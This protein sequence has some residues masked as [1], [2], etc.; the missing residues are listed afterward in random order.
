MV[1]I[2]HP[3]GDRHR[4]AKAGRELASR[5]SQA[6]LE[7][8]QRQRQPCGRAAESGGLGGGQGRGSRR[9]YVTAACAN[10]TRT[11]NRLV[12]R[13]W[14]SCSTSRTFGMPKA[15]CMSGMVVAILIAILFLVDLAVPRA[16]APF[17]KA[18]MHDGH[19]DARL[20][21]HARS[22]QLDDVSGAGVAGRRRGCLTLMAQDE[23]SPIGRRCHRPLRCRPQDR[24]AS[25]RLIDLGRDLRPRW[26]IVA[27]VQLTGVAVGG[28]IAAAS[29]RSAVR[30]GSAPVST[31]RG[32]SICQ[33]QSPAPAESSARFRD[34]S[35]R[36]QAV[37]QRGCRRDPPGRR[38][39]PDAKAD[40]RARRVCGT[41]R[42]IDGWTA[43]GRHAVVE[44]QIEIAGLAR[45]CAGP[46]S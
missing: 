12:L 40:R 10:Y 18:S 33:V 29:D 37:H 20:R 19:R 13:H 24:P 16:M 9:R 14:V 23:A 8:A 15:L 38:G 2:G 31:R 42:R 5:R 30:S 4:R 46:A 1:K 45:H 44:K 25:G 21:R 43:E 3:L 22:W 11:A 39:L 17:R 34:E 41:A 27:H 28:G 26:P 32:A 35:A 7:S 6:A 36:P